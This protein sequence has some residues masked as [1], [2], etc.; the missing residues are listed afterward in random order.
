MKILLFGIV[1]DIVDNSE[2][3]IE[4]DSEVTVLQLKEKL[5]KDYPNLKDLNKFAFAINEVY[6]NDNSKIKNTDIVA[7]IPP[8]SGG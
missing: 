3:I 5:F 4:L 1:K 8:V 7:I 2:I 6:A